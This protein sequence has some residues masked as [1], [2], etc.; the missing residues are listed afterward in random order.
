MSPCLPEPTR[1]LRRGVL[2]QRRRYLGNRLDRLKR[3]FLL[4]DISEADYVRERGEMQTELAELPRPLESR[5]CDFEGIARIATDAR[6]VW[7]MSAPADRNALLI[8]LVE[9]I[10]INGDRVEILPRPDLTALSG[11][12]R[13]RRESNPRSRP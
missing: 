13:R 10:V 9:S 11:Q 8:C 6:L 1:H 5:R 7:D 4:G 3:L 2:E 12:V